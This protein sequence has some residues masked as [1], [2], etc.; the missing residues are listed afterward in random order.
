MDIYAKY[1]LQMMC[2]FLLIAGNAALFARVPET[3]KKL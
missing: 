2:V 1:R 3:P